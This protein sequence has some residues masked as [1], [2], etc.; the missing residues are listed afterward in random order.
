M[1]RARS[2]SQSTAWELPW[3]CTA[4]RTT[5]RIAARRPQASPFTTWQHRSFPLPMS[6]WSWANETDL[7]D[8]ARVAPLFA[9]RMRPT[10]AVHRG[11]YTA[12][13]SDD[14]TKPNGDNRAK[15]TGPLHTSRPQRRYKHHMDAH[16]L[17]SAT[18]GQRRS[19][20]ES[21]GCNKVRGRA[22]RQRRLLRALATRFHHRHQLAEPHTSG[23]HRRRATPGLDGRSVRREALGAL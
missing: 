1:D 18:R 14:N 23:L 22:A 4:T 15:R 2:A 21:A 8:P 5:A 10:G 17:I 13:A 9:S 11:K 7:H 6:S 3:S 19:K 12:P 20:Q 16:I